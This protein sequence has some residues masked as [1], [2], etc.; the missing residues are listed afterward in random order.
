LNLDSKSYFEVGRIS[1][2][3]QSLRR[4]AI[5]LSGLARALIPLEAS[6]II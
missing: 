5:V 1:Q 6:H 2:P 3:S 4:F